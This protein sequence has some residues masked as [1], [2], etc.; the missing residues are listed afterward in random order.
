MGIL[1]SD[2]DVPF[3]LNVCTYQYV[4]AVRETAIPISSN[5]LRQDKKP[6]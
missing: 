3:S 2:Y 1:G 4:L 5:G 6:S